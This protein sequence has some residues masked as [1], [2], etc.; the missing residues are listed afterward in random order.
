MLHLG[1]PEIIGIFVLSPAFKWLKEKSRFSSMQGNDINN[2]SRKCS[3]PQLLEA[4]IHSR[5]PHPLGILHHSPRFLESPGPRRLSPVL[6]AAWQPAGFAIW[7][8]SAWPGPR[9]TPWV[10][11][12]PSRGP[13]G[14]ESSLSLCRVPHLASHL[15]RSLL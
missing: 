10:T 2:T 11:R 7:S 12:P 8:L 1:H 4:L 9:V 13:G 6:G 3:V 5:P 15:G 14:V